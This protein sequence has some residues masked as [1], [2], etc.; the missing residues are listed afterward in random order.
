[1]D[2]Y[3]TV[4]EEVLAHHE[5]VLQA[6]RIADMEVK[7]LFDKNKGKLNMDEAEENN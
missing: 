3:V 6:C 5:K 1:M 2:L 7:Q 4:E